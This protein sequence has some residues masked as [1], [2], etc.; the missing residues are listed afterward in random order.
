MVEITGSDSGHGF[1]EQYHAERFMVRRAVRRGSPIPRRISRLIFNPAAEIY[2]LV[3]SR[4]FGSFVK[5]CTFFA[6]ASE[7][8]RKCNAALL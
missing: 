4:L 1:D 7:Y 6:F 3:Q 5:C 2:M 8:G